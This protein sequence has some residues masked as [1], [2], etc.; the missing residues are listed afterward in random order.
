[1]STD[2]TKIEVNDQEIDHE[3]EW[4]T[5]MGLNDDP[6]VGSHIVIQINDLFPDPENTTKKINFCKT[7]A[8]FPAAIHRGTGERLM[9][10]TGFDSDEHADRMRRLIYFAANDPTKL[11]KEEK[12]RIK[13][14]ILDNTKYKST[15]AP[16]EEY[17]AKRTEYFN[18]R[19]A[20]V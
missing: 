8:L 2:E 12:D 14:I 16:Y 19:A 15:T 5:A 3:E 4:Q 10:D 9:A 6:N 7:L 1:M 11:N 17:V 18:K 13:K 20:T